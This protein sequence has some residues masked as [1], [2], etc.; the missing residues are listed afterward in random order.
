M[1]ADNEQLINKYI[2]DK[3]TE[4]EFVEIQT[5]MVKDNAFAELLEDYLQTQLLFSKISMHARE[6][7][8]KKF[9]AGYN[10]F[11][12]AQNWEND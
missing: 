1:P 4:D 12:M 8:R 6:K 3:L 11:L 10:E 7:K 9:K 5:R 2:D